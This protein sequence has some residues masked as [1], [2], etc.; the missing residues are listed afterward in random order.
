MNI[1]FYF[2]IIAICTRYGFVLGREKKVRRREFDRTAHHIHRDGQHKK[3]RPSKMKIPPHLNIDDSGKR[4]TPPASMVAA[5]NPETNSTSLSTD[6]DDEIAKHVEMF[7]IW[8]QNGTSPTKRRRRRRNATSTERRGPSEEAPAE[9]PS[10]GL[11]TR[12]FVPSADASARAAIFGAISH[13]H[14]R[15]EKMI[16][17]SMTVLQSIGYDV[18]IILNS[19]SGCKALN[20]VKDIAK[21]VDLEVNWT[22]CNVLVL[23]D[24][25]SISEHTRYKIFFAFGQTKLPSIRGLGSH[26]NA[27]F[28]SFPSDLYR[29]AQLGEWDRLSSY[30][31]VVVYSSHA[32]YHYAHTAH[33]DYLNI[34]ASDALINFPSLTIVSPPC[35]SF[36][37]SAKIEKQSSKRVLGIVMVGNFNRV[38]HLE[39]FMFALTL[40]Q[41]LSAAS[42]AV[43]SHMYILGSSALSETGRNAVARLQGI[44]DENSLSVDIVADPS[45]DDMVDAYQRS[46]VFWSLFGIGQNTSVVNAAEIGSFG[47]NIVEAMSAGCIPIA[48]AKGGAVDIIL[49]G[50]NGFLVNDADEFVSY[51]LQIAFSEK[52]VRDKMKE[53]AVARSEQF[54]FITFSANLKKLTAMSF[55]SSSFRNFVSTRYPVIRKHP[56]LAAVESPKVAVMIEPSV[57]YFFEYSVRSALAQLGPTWRLIVYHSEINELFVVEILGDIENIEFRRL[58]YQ[59][60]LNYDTWI[61]K[62][63]FWESLE[64]ETALLFNSASFL[65]NGNI[66]S[67]LDVDF[68]WCPD[69]VGTTTEY[70]RGVRNMESIFTL[71]SVSTMIKICSQH[72]GATSLTEPYQAYFRKFIK[73]NAPERVQYSFCWN[74]VMESALFEGVKPFAMVS[75]WN[76]G[77]L[78]WV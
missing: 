69:K 7:K 19:Q 4:K 53:N 29:Y 31:V 21:S 27:Y 30:D 48:A 28:C 13:L 70:N 8:R 58:S 52:Y 10:K 71:H 72:T 39:Y 55:Y 60:V 67:F 41:S 36:G 15:S 14:G 44:V 65:L 9:L 45:R 73:N 22:K 5:A 37:I 61:K 38:R 75:P 64:A 68:L 35:K 32:G 40:L 42:K 77:S 23:H 59:N 6:T 16:F 12:E 1:S 43:S 26:T 62:A 2:L 50:E 47:M 11:S 78:P 3:E 66:N 74:H 25:E 56:L 17:S 34:A 33:T 49:H 51:S 20:C 76:F 24:Y 63:S 18:D 57:N 54:D 46:T